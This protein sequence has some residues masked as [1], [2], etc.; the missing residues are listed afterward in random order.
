MQVPWVAANVL[1]RLMP[2]AHLHLV[3]GGGH[4]AYYV[5][6]KKTQRQ[7]LESLLKSGAKLKED[8]RPPII[9]HIPNI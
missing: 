2:A 3:D 7:A 9:M 1:H 5:C 6:D 4:F 8:S